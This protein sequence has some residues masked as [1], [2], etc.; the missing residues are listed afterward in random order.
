MVD[1]NAVDR[2]N[3][4][5]TLLGRYISGDAA[6]DAQADALPAVAPPVKLDK[7]TR[8]D[9]LVLEFF[10]CCCCGLLVSNLGVL[11][12]A[13]VEVSYTSPFLWITSFFSAYTENDPFI[14][15]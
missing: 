10:L 11:W 13:A 6:V 4:D 15:M 9:D 8:G 14:T 5:R 3:E 7:R 2:K 1:D 12:E